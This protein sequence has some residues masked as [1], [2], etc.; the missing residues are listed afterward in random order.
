MA[1]A[2]HRSIRKLLS[3]TTRL[4]EIVQELNPGKDMTDVKNALC[5]AR[6]HLKHAEAFES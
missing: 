5:E 6:E 1:K 2:S 3:V 4:A